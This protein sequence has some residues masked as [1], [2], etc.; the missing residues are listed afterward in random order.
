MKHSPSARVSP[1]SRRCSDIKI[2]SYILP[3][4]GCGGQVYTAQTPN[5][6]VL[7][8][9]GPQLV[10][11]GRCPSCVAVIVYC[12]RDSSSFISLHGAGNIIGDTRSIVDCSTVESFWCS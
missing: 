9:L 5:H 7:R 8:I 2:E 4:V 6:I 3:G 1:G 12:D 11:A 10:I